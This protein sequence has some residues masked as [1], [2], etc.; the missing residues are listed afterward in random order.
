MNIEIEIIIRAQIMILAARLNFIF[1]TFSSIIAA[2]I[3]VMKTTT[4]DHVNSK[5][6]LISCPTI[7]GTIYQITKIIHGINMLDR[8]LENMK[9]L[10]SLTF[11]LTI[12]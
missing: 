3:P 7:A 2:I 12:K 10:T 5:A 11:F 1:S 9:E 6:N 8:N 4:N